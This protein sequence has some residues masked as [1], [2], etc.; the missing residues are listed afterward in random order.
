M[1]EMKKTRLADF[2]LYFITD[3]KLTKRTVIDDVKAAVKGGVKII[4]YREKEA[5]AKQIIE[6]AQKINQ[7]CKKNHVLFLVNDRIDVA[8]AIGADGIHIGKEDVPYQYARKLLG[9]GKLI[10]MSA[11]SVKDALQNQQ[12]G[13]DYTSIGPIYLTTTKKD[14]KLSIGLSPI[15]QLKT[16]LRIPF[17]AIGGINES[18]I[19]GVLEAGARNIAIISGIATKTNVESSV[20][21]FVNKIRNNNKF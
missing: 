20:K 2:G 11:H 13:A 4:Q 1:F 6:Y 12:L 3:S 5:P 9:K 14:A 8:L 15:S 19:D 17:V 7:I 16:K 21:M 18:N 10:G